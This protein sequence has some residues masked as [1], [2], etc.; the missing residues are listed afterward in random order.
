M[1]NA[2][3]GLMAVKWDEENHYFELLEI[4]LNNSL[5][6]QLQHLFK[7]MFIVLLLKE[8]FK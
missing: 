4:P 7:T 8:H 5:N 1:T 2:L 6:N 3:K